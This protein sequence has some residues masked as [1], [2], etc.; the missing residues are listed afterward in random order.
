[1]KK[2]ISIIATFYNEEKSIEKFINRIDKSFKK[3]KKIDYDL[4]FIDDCST[5]S[6]NILIKKKQ[7]KNKK[8]KI[9]TLIK[10]YGH[11][12]SLQTGFDFISKKNFVAVIDCDLQ[13][14]PELIAKNFVKIKQNETIHFVRKKREDPIFQ[15]FYSYLAYRM[16]NFISKGKII[17]QTSH[18]KILPPIV[19][20][21]VKKNREIDPYWNYLFTKFSLVNKIVYYAK[22]KRVYGSSK[23]TIFTLNPWLNFFSGIN[24]FRKKFITIISTLLIINITTLLLTYYNFYNAIIILFLTLFSCLLIT[25][26]SISSY[27]HY[28]KKKNKRIYCIYK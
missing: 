17:M 16:L 12:L 24:C 5:D 22:K 28:Y 7:K 1:M 25:S 15:K 3:F 27:L 21:K 20:S 23:F 9:K 19:V 11:N 14:D 2:K 13:D 10:R 8:I 18:F 4:I 6:S 26:L